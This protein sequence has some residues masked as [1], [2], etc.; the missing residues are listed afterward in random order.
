M[1]YFRSTRYLPTSIATATTGADINSITGT[2]LFTGWSGGDVTAFKDWAATMTGVVNKYFIGPEIPYQPAKD[3]IPYSPG[4][5]GT[6]PV[7]DPDP[8][9]PTGQVTPSYTISSR[10]GMEKM[11]KDLTALTLTNPRIFGHD[12]HSVGYIPPSFWDASDWD[13]VPFDPTGKTPSEL[14]AFLRPTETTRVIRGIRQLYYNLKPFVDDLN[15]TV[16]EIENWNLEV[17]RHFRRLFGNNNPVNHDPRLYLESRWADERK[18]TTAWDAAYPVGTCPPGS[19]SH[20][21]WTFFPNASDRAEYISAP[22]YENNFVVYPLLESYNT[23]FG[24]FGV[25]GISSVEADLPWSLRLAV[26]IA[27][28]VCTEGVVNHPGPYTLGSRGA[29]GCAWWFTPGSPNSLAYR[30]Q[31]R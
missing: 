5:V 25:E 2:S 12:P 28:W 15:P 20:C 9:P 18:Y 17:I 8:D 16:V 29:F 3:E 22:P 6:C 14:C 13:G 21:G 4:F 24:Q 23:S 10:D 11:V 27:D 19:G 26:I 1:Y 30:G 31:F 7:P